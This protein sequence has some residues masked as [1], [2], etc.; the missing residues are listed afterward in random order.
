MI[1]D[2]VQ[3]RASSVHTCYLIFFMT[4]VLASERFLLIAVAISEAVGEPLLDP[5]VS[6]LAIMGSIVSVRQ[7]AQKYRPQLSFLPTQDSPE[8]SLPFNF[9]MSFWAS[10]NE[11]RAT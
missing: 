7:F 11:G 8:E 1:L 6:A 4:L 2:S 10:A 9:L 3:A 5:L